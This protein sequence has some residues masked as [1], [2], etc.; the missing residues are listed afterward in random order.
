[1]K[2]V[3]IVIPVYN[4]EAYIGKTLHEVVRAD[5]G[6]FEREIVIIDDGSQDATA[7]KITSFIHKN[8]RQKITFLQNKINEGK[9]A[10]LKKGLLK[11]LGEIVIVQDADLE[12]SPRDYPLLLEPF[13]QNNADVVYGSR[14]ISN[15][16]HRVVYFWHFVANT[17]LTFFSNMLTNLNFTDMETGYKV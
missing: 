7:Q 5:I 17:F 2:K 11:T 6:N 13:L 9:G 4:E 12:Y 15:R 3:S 10:S 14:F 16:P 8:K 1:M